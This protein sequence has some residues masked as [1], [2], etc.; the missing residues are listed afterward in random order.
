MSKEQAR[1]AERVAIVTGA[2]RGI[3]GGIAKRF[4]AEG[5][6][7]AVC[8]LDDTAA[9]GT[10]ERIVQAGG[11]AIAESF[12]VQDADAVRGFV[13]HVGATLGSISILVNNAA[14]MPSSAIE[15]MPVDLID[16]VLR[17]NVRAAVVFS[18]AVTPWMRRSG[19]GAVL[20]MCSTQGYHGSPGKAIYA[21]SKAALRV[22]AQ[23]Q[24]KEHASDGIR[25]NTVSPGSIDSPMFENEAIRSPEGRD[26]YYRRSNELH[27][28]GKIGSIE[29]VA[30][31]FAFLASD[32]AAN[33]TAT[34]LRCDGG[35]AVAV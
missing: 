33:I 16:R 26:T 32:E 25:V 1:L 17:I 27:P 31:A 4:A 13:D 35:L 22:L 12:D 19:G 20:H 30:A 24:A 10:A 11:E 5:A 6:R 23:V 18:Q 15:S 3:G 34:D 7:V 2:G 8:D 28:R 9:R 21:A 14:V 29:E